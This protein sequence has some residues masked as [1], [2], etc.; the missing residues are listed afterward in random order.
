M[1][2][3]GALVAALVQLGMPEEIATDLVEHMHKHEQTSVN[4]QSSM[5]SC[6]GASQL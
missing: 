3:L 6:K 4:S 5:E 2:S 1:G